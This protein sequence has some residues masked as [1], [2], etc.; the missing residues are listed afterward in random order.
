MN[1]DWELGI[2]VGANR[3]KLTGTG[4]LTL[5]NGRVLTYQI[6][7]SYNTKSQL[8]KLKLVGEGEAAGSSLSLTTH[9]A[10]MDLTALTGKVLGQPLKYP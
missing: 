2:S 4:T 10:G 9:G 5:S 3:N 1:G 8:S 7:G 6:V